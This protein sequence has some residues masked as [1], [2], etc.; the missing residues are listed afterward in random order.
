MGS[1]K[2]NLIFG[3]LKNRADAFSSYAF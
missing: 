1:T 2:Q 3:G